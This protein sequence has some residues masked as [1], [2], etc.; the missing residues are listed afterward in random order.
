MMREPNIEGFHPI[1]EAFARVLPYRLF[2]VTWLLPGGREVERIHSSDPASYPLGGRKAVIPDD[3]SR[4][5]LGRRE[6]F[7]ANEP[8]GFSAYFP[9]HE[10]IVSLGLGSVINVPVLDG[11]RLLGTLN[12]L[13]R[14]GAYRADLLKVCMNM[15]PL[16]VP[17]FRAHEAAMRPE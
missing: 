17:A 8:A 12:F 1:G 3:W 11:E 10:F 4:Q 7:F 6:C 9:D 2:T 5:V 16:A 14:A 15:A 13:D